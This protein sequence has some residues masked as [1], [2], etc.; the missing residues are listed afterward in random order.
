MRQIFS[1]LPHVNWGLIVILAAALGCGGPTKESIEQRG[2]SSDNFRMIETAYRK[3]LQETKRAPKN[4]EELAKHLPPGTD[5]EQLFVSPHDQK[6]IVV[7]WGVDLNAMLTNPRPTIYGYE[8]DGVD[9][10]RFVLTTMGVMEMTDED[11]AAASFPEGHSP[12]Q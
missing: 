7:V 1:E 5:A 12:T 4:R 2:E 10:N 11:F 8:A 6:P 3:A 9:G